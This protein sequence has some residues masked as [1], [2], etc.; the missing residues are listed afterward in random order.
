MA[1]HV[2][3]ILYTF[4]THRNWS[5][6]EVAGELEISPGEYEAIE[7]GAENVDNDIAQKLSQLYNAPSAL[8]FPNNS[9]SH[10]NFEYTH[11]TLNSSNA[12]VHNLYQNDIRVVEMLMTAKEDEIKFLKKEIKRLQDQNSQLLVRL[13]GSE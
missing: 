13:L 1:V 11:T 9:S 4:R 2:R 8:F 12:Y 10:I 5:Q 3:T 6:Q 7:A